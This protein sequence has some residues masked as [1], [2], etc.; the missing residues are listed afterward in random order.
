[1]KN[2]VIP[3]EIVLKQ[4]T[5]MVLFISGLLGIL[6]LF[7]M[8]FH[9]GQNILISIGESLAGREILREKCAEIIRALSM[10]G[11][12]SLSIFIITAIKKRINK[13]EILIFLFLMIQLLSAS[14]RNMD[15]HALSSYLLSYRYGFAS[16][17]FI[18][19][20]VDLLLGGG[21][22]S[23]VFVYAF[24]FCG[25][26]YLCLFISIILGHI[27]QKSE[28]HLPLLFLTIL[29]LSSPV[30]PGAYFVRGNFGRMELYIFIFI[31]IIFSVVDKKLWRWFIPVLCF[32]SIATHLVSIFFYMP[33]VLIIL[34]YKYINKTN[35]NKSEGILLI[36][37]TVIITLSFIYFV[38]FSK[39]ALIF[40][41]ED[42]FANALKDKTDIE[43][44]GSSLHYDYFLSIADTFKYVT[45]NY[46][47]PITTLMK[48]FYCILQNLPIFLFFILFWKNC[49]IS[50]QK[51]S[52]KF[53][54]LISM[55][56]PLLSLPAF[57]F[58]VD[59]GRWVIM[60]LTVQFM[61]TLYFIYMRETAVLSTVKRFTII[62]QENMYAAV[63]FIML[64]VFF[65]PIWQ[66]DSSE[67]FINLLYLPIKIVKK[68]LEI[69]GM[70]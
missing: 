57:I 6:G 50:E 1:M 34:V 2:Y 67:N 36:L 16:R 70:N 30:S 35:K 54:F 29:Y 41:N 17:M 26:V 39:S 62:V 56:L 31:L 9:T 25:T 66:I 55:F 51:K 23:I 58:F 61:L 63:L 11:I 10:I 42:E 4:K 3:E 68:I 40:Q 5:R 47:N 7:L 59:W 64:L 19:T 43:S 15:G 20:I 12:T 13:Y 52:M 53:I 45:A 44:Y 8:F 46:F 28:N 37:T 38:V 18:G 65:G 48:K 14:N 27:I 60:L 32:M 33:L 21:F 49:F 22:V 24:V 69:G